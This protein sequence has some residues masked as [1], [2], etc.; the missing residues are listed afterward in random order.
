M[1]KIINNE[2]ML[3]IE[4]LDKVSGGTVDQ[5]NEIYSAIEKQA[6]VAG[7]ISNAVRGIVKEIPAVGAAGTS[8]WRNAAAPMAELV[9]KKEYGID[10]KISI[11]WVGT[12][13]RESDN[14]YSRNGKSLTHQEVLGIMNAA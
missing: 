2:E 7:D 5:F 4:E 9:L 12:G 1:T 13:F 11:G 10:A 8:I 3:N 14:Q 6:G